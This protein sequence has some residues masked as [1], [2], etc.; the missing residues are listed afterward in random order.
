M[1]ITG[2]CIQAQ[3]KKSKKNGTYGHWYWDPLSL[4]LCI[5]T[6]TKTVRGSKIDFT[7]FQLLL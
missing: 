5:P 1:Y 6:P 7:R 3:S 4:R 2:G